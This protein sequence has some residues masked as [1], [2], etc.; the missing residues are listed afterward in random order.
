MILFTIAY[1]IKFFFQLTTLKILIIILFIIYF[2]HYN[3]H[4][5]FFHCPHY[6]LL[7]VNNF[8]REILKKPYFHINFLI[9]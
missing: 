9:Y 6:Y 4:C 5:Y 8:V 2:H 3:V 1:L 7:A